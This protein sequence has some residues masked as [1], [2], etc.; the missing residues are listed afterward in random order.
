MDDHAQQDAGET[1]RVIDLGE[2]RQKKRAHEDER[3]QWLEKML[4]PGEQVAGAASPPE[5]DNAGA[6]VTS[7]LKKPDGPFRVLL[8]MPSKERR[9]A[10]M[11]HLRG[12]GYDVVP[13]DSEFD[14]ANAQ[15]L[16]DMAKSTYIDGKASPI[17]L[18]ITEDTQPNA[19]MTPLEYALAQNKIRDVPVLVISEYPQR[20]HM[21]A[22]GQHPPSPH[23]SR[24]SVRALDA[25]DVFPSGEAPQLEMLGR[26]AH[27]LT[28]QAKRADRTGG[29]SR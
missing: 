26:C 5:S 3:R 25:G 23:M 1:S 4:R 22:P 15:S 2:R 7:A 24:G 28:H 17:Y 9:S 27:Q 10:V 14:P 12:L 11:E 6:A 21:F 18:L 19:V 16:I 13:S 29:Y 8:M 20:Y